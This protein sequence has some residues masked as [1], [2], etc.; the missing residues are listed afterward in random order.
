[1]VRLLVIGKVCFLELN[2]GYLLISRP[3]KRLSRFKLLSTL[4]DKGGSW[5]CVNLMVATSAF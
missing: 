4:A 3:L 5:G 2:N 1:M